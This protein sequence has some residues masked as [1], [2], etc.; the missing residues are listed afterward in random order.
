MHIYVYNGYFS[1]LHA[2]KQRCM[3]F[4]KQK[5]QKQKQNNIVLISA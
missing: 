3:L 2:A 1:L 4:E 5:K